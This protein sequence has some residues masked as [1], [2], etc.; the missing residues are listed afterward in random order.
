MAMSD[1]QSK[2]ETDRGQEFSTL[3]GEIVDSHAAPMVEFAEPSSGSLDHPSIPPSE[4]HHNPEEEG[5]ESGFSRRWLTLGAAAI[6][7]VGGGWF[8]LSRPSEHHAAVEAQTVPP[9][10]VST[11]TVTPQAIGGTESLTGTVEPVEVV[12][13]TSRV[14]GQIISLPVK[15]GDRVKAGQVLAKIDVKDINAQRSQAQ[16]AITQAQAGVT[17]A[18]AAETQA[19]AGEAQVAAQLNQ[20]EAQLQQAQAQVRQTQAQLQQAQAQY[21]NAIAQKQ[22]VQVELANAQLT[23]K[24]QVMLRQEGAIG[25]ASLDAANTQVAVLQSRVEQAIAGID[26][27]RQGVEQARSGI[28]QAQAG[29]NQAQAGIKRAQAAQSQAQAQ[30]QQARAA[31]NQARAQ[32]E[33]ARANK[34]QVTANLDYGTVT[35]P[36]N[37]VVT[38]KHTEVGAM[39]GAGQPIVTLENTTKQRFSVDVPESYISQIKQGDLVKIRLDPIKQ[40]I[41]GKVDRLIPAAN[42]NSHSFNIKIALSSSGL[43][44]GMFGRLEIP[45][46]TRQGISVPTT[47]LI[48]RGQL[49]GVYA[50]DADNRALLR[51]VKTGKVHNGYVEIVS[52]LSSGDRVITSNLSQLQDG[53]AVN[54]M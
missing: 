6:A 53:Q 35:A 9:I 17:V 29:V 52:G 31:I 1:L 14:M 30:V 21:R 54:T 22:S 5:V 10:Q 26:Q 25:Q 34:S 2:M 32:V 24:R 36:F 23:Q 8:F 19:I 28:A 40:V 4:L 46:T 7:L 50:I 43:I 20:A 42:P 12:T 15:E 39:A 37:G 38:R 3:T 33:Q 45:G 18:Q 51:W 47:A 13:T 16:A 41:N 11:Q 49:E 44:S 48:R 27:A